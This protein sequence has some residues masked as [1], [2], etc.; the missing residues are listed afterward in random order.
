MV[1]NPVTNVYHRMLVIELGT[2]LLTEI[3]STFQI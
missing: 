1:K 2:R 3:N